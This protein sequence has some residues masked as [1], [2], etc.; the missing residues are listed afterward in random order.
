[1]K[2]TSIIAGSLALALSAAP[3]A[4]AADT[5]TFGSLKGTEADNVVLYLNDGL[6]LPAIGDMMGTSDLNAL[7]R[8]IRASGFDGGFGTHKTFYGLGDF[9][10]VTV[11]GTGDGPLTRRQLHDLGGHTAA[12]PGDGNLAVVTAG[13]NTSVPTPASE[14]AVG[15]G[16]GD[17]T[18]T[19]YKTGMT[20]QK[21]VID[22]PDDDRDV[23]FIV[24]N[25]AAD[26]SRM[27]REYTALIDGVTLTRDLG[28]EPGMSVYPEEFVKRVQAAAR[29]V[30][31]LRL[32]VL[33][34]RELEREGMG[35]ILGVGQGSVH[36]PS[37]LILEYRGAP[38][39]DAP[40]A[41]VGK[42]ITFDT[43]GI[44]LKPNAG[45][46]LMKS[47]LSGAAAVAGTLLAT[48]KRGADVNVVGLMP[49][50]ENM[51]GPSAIRPGDVLTTYNGTTIE[52]MSTDAEGRLLLADSVAYAQA[53][54]D[55]ELLV[56]IATLTGSAARAM[57]DDY[58][59]MLTRDW[60]LAMEMMEV[61]KRAGEEVW[62]LP[63]H[64]SHFDQI[65][66]DIADIKSTAGSPG[67]S[68]GAAVVGT[69]VAQDQPW[70]HLDIAGVD[71]R[72]SATPTAPKGHAGWGVRFMD[73][74]I[75]TYEAK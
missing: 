47:D 19:T 38:A 25:P 18:F 63:L 33:G 66:S 21:G 34:L 45:Q 65:D 14:I 67:A 12:A 32:T 29:G 74:L 39:S 10:A 50:A 7:N 58:G 26:Q 68:I 3:L 52:V 40:I 42:G 59:A 16:L 72:E 23:K 6:S 56:N 64:D 51:P 22:R 53:K 13:L 57:G 9:D 5:V 36:D 37:L 49:L 31:N 71:W 70:V 41:L 44:S 15:Y 28:N 30:P 75:R 54:Y 61:G 69:F 24:S 2:R 1:M 48:A 60:D 46:W 62:P 4:M 17:Y 8:A 11:I 73:E 35:G 55:P 27:D 43:G 20:G